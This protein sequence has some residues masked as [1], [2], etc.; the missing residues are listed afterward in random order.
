MSVQN[1]FSPAFRSSRPEIDVCEE[2]GLAFLPWSPLGGG[3][4]SGKYKR[5]ERPALRA[6]G[7][8]AL[9]V[10]QPHD[11][12]ILASFRRARNRSGL[13]LPVFNPS[14]PAIS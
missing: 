6:I 8:V 9:T 12:K 2:L 10:A 7:F 3:W 1:Q 13:M 4:L 14:I 11:V 5:D